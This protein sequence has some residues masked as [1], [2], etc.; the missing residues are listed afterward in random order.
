LP[1]DTPAAVNA[2]ATLPQQ[3]V[4]VTSLEHIA[5]QSRAANV[6]APALVVIGN[7]VRTREH[8]L[9]AVASSACEN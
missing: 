1:A 3:Q 2:S 9:D 5:A 7:I 8:I 6:A 4:L